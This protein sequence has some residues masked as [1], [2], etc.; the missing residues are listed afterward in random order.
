MCAGNR[1]QYR[2]LLQ[3][4]VLIQKNYRAFYWRRKFLLL[5]WAALTFQKQVRGQRARRVCRQ[6]QEERRKR[7][8]EE[9]EERRRRKQQQEEEEEQERERWVC[10]D[11]FTPENQSSSVGW[12]V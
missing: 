10:L 9:L 5:R 7:E 12:P 11:W 6:L 1:K 8:E 3:S 2:K 4:I